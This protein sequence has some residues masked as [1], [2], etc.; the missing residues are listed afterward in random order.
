MRGPVRVEADGTRVYRNGVRY[1]P[2]APEDR[3]YGVN[4]PDDPRAVRFHGQW[5]LPIEV[6][7]DEARAPVPETRSD[8]DAYEHAKRTINCRCLVCLRPEAERW[9]RKWLRELARQD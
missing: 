2:V 4:K 8:E 5:F 7:P 9:R 6:L 3:K 1:K